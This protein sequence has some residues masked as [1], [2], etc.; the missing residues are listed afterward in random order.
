MIARGI[1]RGL[2]GMM[3]EARAAGLDPL[4]DALD[5]ARLEAELGAGD[6][7]PVMVVDCNAK[8]PAFR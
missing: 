8:S 1:S 2:P 7:W 6:R 3:D 4:A 5:V